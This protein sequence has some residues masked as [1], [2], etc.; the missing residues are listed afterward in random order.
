MLVRAVA[1]VD[2]RAVDLL[3]EQLDRTGRMMP[4]DQNVGAHG[5]EG[6]RGVEQRL[7]LAH[8]RDADRHVH[9]VGAETLAGK[10]EGGLRAG[11]GFEEQVDLSAAAERSALLLDLPVER[12]KLLCEIEQAGDVLGGKPLDTQQVTAAED[13]RGFWRNVH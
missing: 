10:L 13:E 8:G 2:D 7:A 6:D 3:G 9:H 4:D 5:I 1:G 11:R 12:D